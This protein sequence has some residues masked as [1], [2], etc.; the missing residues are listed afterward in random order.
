[1]LAV[2]IIMILIEHPTFDRVVGTNP[3]KK[4]LLTRLHIYISLVD[5][6]RKPIGSCLSGVI[7]RNQPPC[8][9]GDFSVARAC[10]IIL[11]FFDQRGIVVVLKK[12]PQHNLVVVV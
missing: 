12:L 2:S 5:A 3:A 4:L 10:S 1:M 9:T 11:V 6:L 8:C 7:G